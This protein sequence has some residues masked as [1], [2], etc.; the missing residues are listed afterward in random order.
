MRCASAGGS[1]EAV[2]VGRSTRMVNPDCGLPSIGQFAA[3]ATTLFVDRGPVLDSPRIDADRSKYRQWIGGGV[4]PLPRA[5]YAECSESLILISAVIALDDLDMTAQQFAH[6]SSTIR[7]TS[8][9]KS[10]PG[11]R[12][13][14]HYVDE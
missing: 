1:P 7:V 5:R 2:I 9:R 10:C 12:G 11:H 14:R 6:S 13:R 4:S 3:S 8:C